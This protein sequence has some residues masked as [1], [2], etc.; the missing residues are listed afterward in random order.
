MAFQ[1]KQITKHQAEQLNELQ[2]DV[3]Q[4]AINFPLKL[5]PPLANGDAI[6]D[7]ACGSGAVSESIMALN[8]PDLRIEAT[9]INEQF[10]Q[11]V[12]ALATDKGW[13]VSTAVMPAECEL[14]KTLEFGGFEPENISCQKIE[15][16]LQATGP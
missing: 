4:Q 1:P 13:P 10:A 14:R 16:H 15:C 3:S 2:G 7:N 5:V 8:P 11:A 9:D 12:A 6:H